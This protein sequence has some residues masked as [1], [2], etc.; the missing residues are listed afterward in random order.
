MTC[1]YTTPGMP[2]AVSYAHERAYAARK[3]AIVFL[4]I[5]QRRAARPTATASISLR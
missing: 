3:D 4:N 5:I 1:P 2:E